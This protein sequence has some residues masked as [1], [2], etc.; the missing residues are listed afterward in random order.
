ML[1][2]QA[3]AVASVVDEVKPEEE[4]DDICMLPAEVRL[5]CFLIVLSVVILEF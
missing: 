5:L 2:C 3:L 1:A 4:D